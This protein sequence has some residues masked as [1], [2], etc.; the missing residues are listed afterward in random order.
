MKSPTTKSAIQLLQNL[1]QTSSFS[2]EEQETASLIENWL[3]EKGIEIQREH[4]NIWAFNK[5]FDS[6]KPSILLNSHHDTVRPNSGYTRNPHEAKIEDGKLFGLG[7]NDAGGCLVS[8][9]STFAYFYDKENLKYNLVIV[10][11][12]EEE[13]SGPNSLRSVLDKLPNFEFG[14]VGEPTEMNLAIAEKGLLV[15]DGYAKGIAG[16]AAHENTQNAIYQALEDVDWIRNYEFEK[17]SEMLGKVKMSV[18]QIEAG[19]QHNLV[20][21]SCH[22]VVD[23]RLNEHYSNRKIFEF[24]SSNTKSEIKARSFNLNSSFISKSH[25]IVQAGL[26]LGKQTYGSP[27]LSDQAVLDFP[28]LK[29][30]PGVSARSHSADEFIEIREIEEGIEIYKQL[31]KA[32]L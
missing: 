27:T 20:P 1:I 23:V 6:G 14:I 30:G 7:S 29:I 11:S 21:A 24:I 5:C 18:T 16:H 2:G 4:N 26:G 31:L 17:V 32:I 15:L 12:A 19:K 3:Q 8:L 10:A 13:N 25:P 28:S 22:F 9:L